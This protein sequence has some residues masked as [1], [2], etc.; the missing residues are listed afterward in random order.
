MHV[1]S[2][3]ALFAF[4][5]LVGCSSDPKPAP[6]GGARFQLRSTDDTTAPKCNDN[7]PYTIALRD[8]QN[9]LKLVVDGTDDARVRCRVT[10]SDFSLSVSNRNAA[11]SISGKYAGTSGSDVSVTVVTSASS[12]ASP[13]D[14]KCS[15]T[16]TSNEGGKFAGNLT[17]PKLQHQTIAAVCTFAPSAYF[18]FSNCTAE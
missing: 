5:T 8:D 6:A 7:Q 4:A 16:I 13:N 2:T 10:A 11:L 15:V 1:R 3:A 9:E 12:Y 14:A 18:Q 17:C